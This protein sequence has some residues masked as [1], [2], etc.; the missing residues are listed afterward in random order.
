MN[1]IFGPLNFRSALLCLVISVAAAL[2]AFVVGHALTKTYSAASTVEVDLNSEGGVTDTV[3]TAANDLAS[4]LAQL[5]SSN[6][7]VRLAEGKLHVPASSLT[8]TLSGSTVA[9][10]NLVQITATGSNASEAESRATAGAEAF[11]AYV[12]GLYETYADHYITSVQHGIVS[13]V[14]VPAGDVTPKR[15]TPYGLGLSE[16]EASVISESIR[17]AAGNVPDLQMVNAGGS[18]TVTSPQPKLY[19]LVAFVVAL[20]ITFRIAFMVSRPQTGAPA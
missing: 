5:V 6:P 9:A 1:K 4:Q 3:V 11:M 7:V 10:Q 19:A 2:A 20:L 13:R 17:D 8:G 16:Q 14:P 12:D 15:V 18:A